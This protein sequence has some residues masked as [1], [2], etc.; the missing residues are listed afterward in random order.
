MIRR[1]VHMVLLAS[2]LLAVGL[3]PATGRVWAGPVAVEADSVSYAEDGKVVLAQGN[4]RVNWG[5]SSFEASSVVYEQEAGQLE[6]TGPLRLETPD[7][8]ASAAACASR[9]VTET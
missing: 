5:Q 1:R 7:L 9:S 8:T 2:A 3:V 4:V 6:V